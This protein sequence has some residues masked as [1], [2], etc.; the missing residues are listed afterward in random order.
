MEAAIDDLMDKIKAIAQGP[1]A[2]LLRKLVD[3]LYEQAA[4]REEYDE[5]PFSAEDLAA[6]QEGEEAF[7]R[8]EFISLE[9]Y[10][11]ERGL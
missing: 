1:N 10:V 4:P 11:E 9:E 2:E 8:G 5:E 3:V 6:I 7:K